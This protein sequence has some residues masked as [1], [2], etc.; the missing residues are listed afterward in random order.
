MPRSE[1]LSAV[2]IAYFARSGIALPRTLNSSSSSCRTS[3]VPCSSGGTATARRRTRRTRTKAAFRSPR[4]AAHR[5]DG[6][7]WRSASWRTSPTRRRRP[8]MSGT[9]AAESPRAPQIVA[10]FRES[11]R[12]SCRRAAGAMSAGSAA[13][14]SP[15]RRR[16]RRCLRTAGARDELVIL[17][18]MSHS[19]R[20]GLPERRASKRASAEQAE[21]QSAM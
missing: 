21:D 15:P 7:A 2:A 3:T 10:N 12:V 17:A 1:V 18:Q 19:D 4:F 14:S 9:T 16:A 11:P 20:R 8:C 13:R 5:R 6:R